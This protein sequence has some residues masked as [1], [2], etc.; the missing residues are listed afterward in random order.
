MTQVFGRDYSSTYDVLYRDK[1]YETECDTIERIMKARHPSPVR[2]VLDLGCGTGSHAIRLAERGYSVTGI[3][4]SAGM[5]AAAREKCRD[6]GFDCTFLRS[7]IRRFRSR[8]RFDAVIMM[9][10]VLGY[11]ISIEDIR[12]VLETVSYHLRPGGVFICDLWYGPAVLSQKPAEKVRVMREGDTT[13]IRTSSGELDESAQTVRVDFHVWKIE[14]DRLSSE[15]AETHTMRFFFRQE[16]DILFRQAGL[17]PVT[18]KSFSDCTADP[19]ET[20]W[21]VWAFSSRDRRRR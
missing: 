9:F 14:G 4:R 2:S 3:D 17:L 21:N 5:L 15:F 10:A 19:D 1:D 12:A 11:F 7:D 6:A 16:L 18:V 8:V 13:V 20:T